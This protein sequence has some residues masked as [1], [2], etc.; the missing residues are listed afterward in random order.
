MKQKVVK[1]ITVLL[2]LGLLGVLFV[3][4]LHDYELSLSLWN[5]IWEGY[6]I[7]DVESI[8]N[9]SVYYVPVII[10]LLLVTLLESRVRYGI[11]L[12]S[13]GLGLSFTLTRYLYPALVNGYQFAVYQMGLYLLLALECAVIL[14]SLIGICLKENAPNRR[15]ATVDPKADTAEIILPKA[16]M[17]KN[18]K[19]KKSARHMAK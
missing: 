18:K 6:R 4:F 17:K 12:L 19:N 16:V 10:G 14:F 8:L 5:S 15:L 13:A 7:W 3:P 11:S 1:W 2:H 9:Y